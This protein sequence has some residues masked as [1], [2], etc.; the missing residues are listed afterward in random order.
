MLTKQRQDDLLFLLLARPEA[1]NALS[2]ALVDVL[3]RT[4]DESSRDE[5]VS[6][7][8]LGSTQPSVFA[9]GGDLAELTSLPHDAT[10]AAKVLELGRLAHALEAHP[11]P[12]IAAVNGAAIGGGA[13]VCVACDL[14]VMS[15]NASIR[16]VHG[17]MGLTPAW[18][19]GTRLEERVGSGRASELLFTGRAVSAHEAL[20]MG[21]ANRVSDDAL[22]GAQKLARELTCRPRAA[23]VALKH[24]LATARVRRRKDAFEAEASAFEKAWGQPANLDAFAAVKREKDHR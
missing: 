14:I 18:G 3:T 17:R 12:V 9:S 19:G 7:V 6:A 16:F 10:G 1:R 22:D 4:L 20:A 21:L 23:L 15:Q 24:S 13:E 2:S 11:V 8:V 5:S